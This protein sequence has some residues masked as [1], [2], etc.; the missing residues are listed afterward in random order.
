[1]K[2][3][4]QDQRTYK[5]N[6]KTLS[7][8]VAY[9][10]HFLKVIQDEVELL[11][12]SRM[13]REYILH[14]G[15]SMVIPVLENGQLIMIEQY[16]HPLNRVFLE[17]PAGKRDSGESFEKT[18]V[19]ELKEETGFETMDLRFLTSI[20]PTI[21]YANEEIQIFLARQLKHTGRHL[22][23][24]EFLNCVEISFAE[25]ETKVKSGEITDVKTQIAF[26]WLDRVL[27]SGW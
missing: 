10:G 24:G 19:R 26:F 20:H 21:G 11:D 16:R 14:P 8:R 23:A 18:A 1:M 12:Q 2:K 13:L 4:D 9:D 22:D 3:H 15:A 27:N 17:F 5:L 25:L 6:E 7:S